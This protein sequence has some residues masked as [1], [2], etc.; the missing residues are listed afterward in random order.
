[1]AQRLGREVALLLGLLPRGG[2][3]IQSVNLSYQKA[4]QGSQCTGV[5]CKGEEG[6]Y[7]TMEV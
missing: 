2:Q 4:I 3:D 6:S 5:S 1:M 7:E